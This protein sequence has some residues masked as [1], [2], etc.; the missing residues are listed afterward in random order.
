MGA[1]VGA[2][3]PFW[4]LQGNEVHCG[5]SMRKLHSALGF[6][7]T[8]FSHFFHCSM[9]NYTGK[10]CLGVELRYQMHAT[11]PYPGSFEKLE[12]KF[13]YPLFVHALH[14]PTFQKLQIIPCSSV[15]H[16]VYVYIAVYLTVHFRQWVQDLDSAMFYAFLRL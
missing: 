2:A 9:Y 3:I 14:F 11:A 8:I 4:G 6:Y 15:R 16:D 13:W 1:L 10:K 5:V 12:K 7:S